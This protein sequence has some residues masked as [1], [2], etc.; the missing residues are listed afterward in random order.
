M[1][2]NSVLTYGEE[3]FMTLV[4]GL[5][6]FVDLPRLREETG[7][8]LVPA[9]MITKLAIMH[10]TN[11]PHLLILGTENGFKW[12]RNLTLHKSRIT[13]IGVS[14]NSVDPHRHDDSGLFVS[15]S[16][17]GSIRLWNALTGECLQVFDDRTPVAKRWH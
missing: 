2:V 7:I 5:L 11:K 6:C 8:W 13:C 12:F 9:P 17:D 14:R 15:G 1:P 3:V 10:F 4:S 16:V